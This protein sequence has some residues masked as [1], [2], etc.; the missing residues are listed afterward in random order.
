M[1][2]TV[3]THI[4]VSALS[5]TA[6]RGVQSQNYDT[7]L[8]EL[9]SRTERPDALVIA[10]R[11]LLRGLGRQWNRNLKPQQQRTASPAEIA[12]LSLLKTEK[13]PNGEPPLP[14]NR[15]VL[16]TSDTRSGE[17]CADLLEHAFRDFDADIQPNPAYPHIHDV[18][19]ANIKGLAITDE[20]VSD[21]ES[22]R[23][24]FVRTGLSNYVR[25]VFA[26]YNSLSSVDTL[27][28]NITSGFKGLVPTA[29]DLVLLL[30]SRNDC[31]HVRMV[32]LYQS[33]SELVWYNSL[34]MEFDWNDISA[35]KL[36]QAGEVDGT[37][38]GLIDSR[39]AYLFEHKEAKRLKRSAIGEVIWT[40]YTLLYPGNVNV[41][42]ADFS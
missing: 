14:I 7:I 18:H 40:L 28:L 39:H 6:L 36:M 19:R 15:L 32:Y 42:H 35:E 11:D 29:R 37:S 10:K 16:V 12:A 1:R 2:H 23:H 3:I 31:P 4:G 41:P 33:S 22:T 25:A 9:A 5:C 8:D 26:E 27:T 17:F 30:G 34:P 13:Q 21:R 24:E 20:R 38:D